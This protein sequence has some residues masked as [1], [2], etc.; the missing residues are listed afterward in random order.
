MSRRDKK[1]SNKEKH[2]IAMLM[3]GDYWPHMNVI[4]VL[5]PGEP[6]VYYCAT[7]LTEISRDAAHQRRARRRV[8]MRKLP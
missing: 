7:R 8:K 1:K 2:A 3:G 6:A 4:M 5:K